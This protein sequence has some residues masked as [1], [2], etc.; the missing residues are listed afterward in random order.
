MKKSAKAAKAAPPR[1][2]TKRT[3]RLPFGRTVRVLGYANGAVRVRLKDA[4]PMVVSEAFLT[5]NQNVILRIDPVGGPPFTPEE[6]MDDHF[7]DLG[8]WLINNCEEVCGAMAGT[9]AWFEYDVYDVKRH[10]YDVAEGRLTI[11]AEV[12]LHGD[13]DPE[14]PPLGDRIT[15]DVEC[16]FELD[17]HGDWALVA[18]EVV[19]GSLRLED[20]R[21]SGRDDD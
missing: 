2:V 18:K 19:S 1:L 15:V 9:N 7:A 16:V 10:S 3:V 4:A 6:V 12:L 20:A 14:R 17:D 5:G 21:Q 8:S 13:Q 11:L